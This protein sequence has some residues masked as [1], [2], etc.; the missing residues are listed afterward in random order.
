MVGH[1]SKAA[2]DLENQIERHEAEL[3]HRVD[4]D[5]SFAGIVFARVVGDRRLSKSKASL[6]SDIQLAHGELDR[7]AAIAPDAEIE[8]EAGIV[9]I[10]G[11]RAVLCAASGLV[12]MIW[13]KPQ[14]A[15]GYFLK[16]LSTAEVPDHHYWLALVYE[17]EGKS[18][19]ALLHFERYLELDPNGDQSVSALREA[20]AMR[21]YKKKFRGNWATFFVL[22]LFWPAAI[23]YLI[24]NWK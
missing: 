5:G 24:K 16:A 3:D 2:D 19:Q 17:T 21:N 12:E 22:L 10:P 15:E 6:E 20:N 11:M 8:T 4:S 18:N 1:I 14:R 9:G 7:A 23:Y 13:G